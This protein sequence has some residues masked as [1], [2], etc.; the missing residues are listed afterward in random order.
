[1]T[2]GTMP[3]VLRAELVRLLA[4]ALVADVRAGSTGATVGDSA[5]EPSKPLKTRKER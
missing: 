5:R 4:D 1:M 2:A 3:E